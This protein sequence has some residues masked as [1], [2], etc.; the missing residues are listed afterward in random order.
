MQKGSKR[1]RESNDD[2]PR[3]Q[4]ATNRAKT[5]ACTPPDNQSSS[6]WGWLLLPLQTFVTGIREGLK[7][8]N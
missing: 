1:V 3:E 8:P 4:P 2:D 7:G 5:E 6:F